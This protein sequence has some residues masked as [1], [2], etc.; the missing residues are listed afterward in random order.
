M[1]CKIC[2]LIFK[3][4]LEDYKAEFGDKAAFALKLLS[5]IYD[6]SERKSKGSFFELNK[7]KLKKK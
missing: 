4:N 1:P 5:G 3:L 6:R 7:K 2:I